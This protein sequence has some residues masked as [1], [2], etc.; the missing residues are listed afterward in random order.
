MCV[1]LHEYCLRI[2]G[3]IHE[4]Y[5]PCYGDGRNT[6]IFISAPLNLLVSRWTR[7]PENNIPQKKCW[8]ILSQRRSRGPTLNQHCFNVSCLSGSSTHPVAHVVASKHYHGSNAD[9]GSLGVSRH[10]RVRWPALDRRCAN[11]VARM[12]SRG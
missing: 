2:D 9:L 7:N 8:Y 3:E 4:I 10:P 6:I 5:S 12:R 1:K 11:V